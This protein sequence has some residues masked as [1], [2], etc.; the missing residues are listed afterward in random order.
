[1]S[2]KEILKRYHARLVCEGA[3]RAALWGAVTGLSLGCAVMGL[4]WLSVALTA[5]PWPGFNGTL[6]AILGAVLI[7]LGAGAGLYWLA[8]RPTVRQTAARV[9]ALGLAERTVTMVDRAEEDTYVACRQR[10]DATAALAAVSPKQIKIGLAKLPLALTVALLLLLVALVI[11]P[12]AMGAFDPPE[13]ADPIDQL[14]ADMI[15]DLR[16]EIDEADMV[17]DSVKEELHDM[18]DRL[19]ESLKEAETAEEKIDLVEQTAEQIRHII[20]ENQTHYLIGEALKETPKTEELGQAVQSGDPEELEDAFDAIWDRISQAVHSPTDGALKEE[21]LDTAAGLDHAI[22]KEGV[23]GDP[24]TEALKDLS[25]ALKEAADLIEQLPPETLPP[26]LE[27]VLEDAEEKIEDAIEEQE[28]QEELKEEL[29]DIIEDALEQLDPTE[30]LPEE[31][32]LPEE[33]QEPLPAPPPAEPE[34]EEP[35]T[36]DTPPELPEPEP[37]DPT[38]PTPAPGQDDYDIAF[39]DGQTPYTDEYE[40]YFKQEMERL[41]KSDL[42]EAEKEAVAAYFAALRLQASGKK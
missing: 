34:P 42:T 3:L 10:E 11:V 19:E 27:D 12:H 9:D 18:V 38:Q 28:K 25:E 32:V 5:W 22:E 20:E 7:A 26:E 8:F 37:E 1:M 30:P 33:P 4:S 36:E 13:P 35:P 6:F 29:E 16:Q 2:I 21:L 24:L 39:K 14:L 41:A 17:R 23:E 31:P 15:A 40:E